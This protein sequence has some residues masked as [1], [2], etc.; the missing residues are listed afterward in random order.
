MDIDTTKQPETTQVPSQPPAAAKHNAFFALFG[1]I[2]LFL[3]IAGG[4]AFGGYYF[5]TNGMKKTT[6]ST[7][8]TPESAMKTAD[9]Q[10]TATAA[11]TVTQKK[12]VKAGLASGTSFKL[13][14]VEIPSSW[15]DTREQSAVGDKLILTKN[16]YSLSIYQ[17]AIGGGGCLYPGDADAMMAQKFTNF[18]EITGKS[19]QFRRSWNI[20]AGATTIAYSVCQKNTT[21]SSYGSP[22]EFGAISAKTPTTPDP[23]IMTELDSIVAS[24]AKQ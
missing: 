2:I 21:D 23:T 3:L 13:Y 12:T 20:E 18:A 9:Q 14:T 8:P 7:T 4:L 24:L 17:A 11:P 15:T 19:V 6:T 1:K 22:T 16:D 10:P 5:G